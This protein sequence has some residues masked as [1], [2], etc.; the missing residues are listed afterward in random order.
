M[1]GAKVNVR[2]YRYEIG[3]DGIEGE[4]KI[5]AKKENSDMS[6]AEGTETKRKST[7]VRKSTKKITAKIDEIKPSNT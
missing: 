5:K 1:Y 6:E 2:A 3:E 7:I 4:S